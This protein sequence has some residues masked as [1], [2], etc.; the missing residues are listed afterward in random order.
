VVV[1]LS[2]RRRLVVSGDMLPAILSAA[3]GCY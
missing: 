1:I 2:P 3:G